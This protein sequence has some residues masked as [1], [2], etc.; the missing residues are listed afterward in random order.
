MSSQLVID[1][2]MNTK[3]AGAVVQSISNAFSEIERA[4][5]STWNGLKSLGKGR[6][7]TDNV[8]VVD[9]YIKKDNRKT[10][11]GSRGRG[12]EDRISAQLSRTNSAAVMPVASSVT[13]VIS[14][15]P[16]SPKDLL[17]LFGDVAKDMEAANKKGNELHKSIALLLSLMKA[18]ND[19][20]EKHFSNLPKFEKK[21][22]AFKQYYKEFEFLLKRE[23][24]MKAGENMSWLKNKWDKRPEASWI[25][26]E[27]KNFLEMEGA[28]P[29]VEAYKKHFS[30]YKP[31]A[32]PL[33]M[34]PKSSGERLND[35]LKRIEAKLDKGI[36]GGTGGGTGPVDNSKATSITIINNNKQVEEAT[37]KVKQYTDAHKR[38]AAQFGVSSEELDKFGIFNV[39]TAAQIGASA[40]DVDE[41]GIGFVSLAGKL[42]TSAQELDLFGQKN[43]TLA[44]QMGV[45]ARELFLFNE[46]HVRTAAQL[47]VSSQELALFKEGHVALA[48][49]LGVTSQEL[50][51]HNE[52]HIRN[53]NQLGVSAQEL[54][55]YKEGHVVLAGQLGVSSKELKLFGKE[56]IITAKNL[57]VSAKELDT[58][59]ENHVKTAGRLGV[60]S[61][62]LRLFGEEHVRSAKKLGVGSV[63]LKTYGDEHIKMANKLGVG[64][65]ELALYDE[66]HIRLAKQL[67]VSSQELDVYGQEHVTL[68]KKIGVSSFELD[69]YGEDHVKL[70]KQLG[71]SSLELEIYGKENI[72]LAKHIGKTASEVMLLTEAEKEEARQKADNIKKNKEYQESLKK[73][74][75]AIGYVQAGLKGTKSLLGTMGVEMDKTTEDI[76]SFAESAGNLGS[77]IISG[78]PTKIISG[79]FDTIGTIFSFF[80][81]KIDWGAKARNLLRGMPG[82]TDEMRDKLAKLAEEIG[83][84][85]KAYRQLLKD[86]V[87]EG[88]TTQLTFDKWANEISKTLDFS[89]INPN[90]RQKAIGEVGAAFAELIKKADEFEQHGSAAMTQII[91]DSRNLVGAW[92]DVKEI[93]DYVMTQLESGIEGLKTYVSDASGL[94]DQIEEKQESMDKLEGKKGNVKQKDQEEYNRLKD[95]IAELQATYDD[96]MSQEQFDRAAAYAVNIM[97]SLMAE[98]K[99][100]VDVIGMMGDQLDL[101]INIKDKAGYDEGILEELLGMREFVNNNK[102]VINGIQGSKQ[103]MESFFNANYMTDDLFKKFQEDA[104]G[105]YDAMKDGAEM[106]EE[107]LQAIAPYL[108]KMVWFAKEHKM[109]LEEGTAE[110]VNQAIQAGI[111]MDVMLPPQEKM[112]YL[113]EELVRLFGGEV[114]YAIEEAAKKAREGMGN[115]AIETDKW[116]KSLDDIEKKL[117]KDIPS[118]VSDMDDTYQHHVSGNTIVKETLK[119]HEALTGVQG[120]ME[121]DLTGSARRMDDQYKYTVDNIRGYFRELIDANEDIPLTFKD[122]QKAV[123]A[124]TNDIELAKQ[125]VADFGEEIDSELQEKID[126]LAETLGNYHA[127]ESQFL[128]DIIKGAEINEYNFDSYADRTREILQDL[129]NGSLSIQETQ[130]AMGSSFSAL[131]KEAQQLGTEGSR[132]MINLLKEVRAVGLEVAEMDD[133]VNK[134]L[135]DGAKAFGT[136]TSS[137]ADTGAIKDELDELAKQYAAI[138]EE[139]MGRMSHED[140]AAK[141]LERDK[142]EEQLNLKKDELKKAQTDIEENWGFMQGAA[143]STFNAL[144]AQ[145]YSLMERVQ[146]MKD[147]LADLARMAKE[148]GLEVSE[149]IRNMVEMAEFME[150]NEALASRIEAT[151]TMMQALGDS[152]FMTAGDF[153]M[154]SQQVQN[155]MAAVEAETGNSELALRMVAPALEDLIKY[156]ESYGYAIDDSTQKLIDQARE[157]GV[158]TEQTKS[159]A[160]IT[161]ELLLLI[162]ETLGATIPESLQKV[163]DQAERSMESVKKETGEWNEELNKVEGKLKDEFPEAILQLDKRYTEAMT[164]N[165][166]VKETRKWQQSLQDVQDIL[167]RQLL[168]NAD[169]LDKKYKHVQGNIYDYL[170]KTSA[171]GFKASLSFNGMVNKLV[172]LQDAHDKLAKKKWRSKRDEALMDDYKRQIGELKDAVEETAPTLENFGK[173][174]DDLQDQ[175]NGPI[176]VN[177]GMIQMA[178]NLREQGKTLEDIDKIIGKS[179]ETGSKGLG[180]WVNALG[181]AVEQ[182]REIKDLRKDYERLLAKDSLSGEETESLAELAGQLEELTGKARMDMVGDTQAILNSQEMM[183]AYFYSL[184]AE[185]KNVFEV[186]ELLGDGFQSLAEKSLEDGFVTPLSGTFSQLYQL[187]RKM[188][189]NSPL[190]RG[191]QGLSGALHGIG[192]SM[193]YMSRESFGTFEQASVQAFQKLRSAGFQQQQAL[194]VMAPILRD[195]GAY[196]SEYGYALSDP[197]TLMLEQAEKAHLIREQQKSDTERLID[198]NMRLADTMDRVAG[199]FTQMQGIDPFGAMQSEAAWLVDENGTPVSLSGSWSNDDIRRFQSIPVRRRNLSDSGTAGNGDIVFEHVTIHGENGEECV[200][201]FMAAIKGNRYG[202]QNLIRKVAN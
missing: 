175:L 43:V 168:E 32:S 112:V 115:A 125:A 102:E 64:S 54:A 109:N 106:S 190:I 165:T 45:N 8:D 140:R 88:V 148:N 151:R 93:Q 63:E 169:E 25:K 130:E 84:V 183:A 76:F 61:L 107:G 17:G 100:M 1:L 27:F 99:S 198:A 120:M 71:V 135:N 111:N 161:N 199:V 29:Q 14:K 133:Y 153:D 155:Q 116:R 164:G 178:R 19:Y 196:A 163:T 108:A 156:S 150:Q 28:S 185:G 149:G 145:G 171:Q 132:S 44:G 5:K 138:E 141:E 91:E 83:D 22:N 41:Y 11:T 66:K 184:Q 49:R 195:L 146:M 52:A 142:L 173:H 20:L 193:I 200:R 24:A 117:T 113:L 127:A 192:D 160:E 57:G 74:D 177:A 3:E 79:V 136:Y 60:S 35:I 97:E 126:E 89:K 67:G 95:E 37:E 92:K 104:I 98:G 119:W 56:D 81:K 188:T 7:V 128:D 46:E 33:R 15:I 87:A 36:A 110:M 123:M 75:D 48:G 80:E 176:G 147:P 143:L 86:F 131:L 124:V 158:L 69:T 202:V 65:H 50:F 34:K 68:A 166:I 16:T 101:L 162:A 30:Q 85:R 179:L 90:E 21:L 58:Y 197:V 94:L 154:F 23:P 12:A 189:E 122:I 51:L 167:G 114:P 26:E 53:A 31:V 78:D 42:G 139:L 59:G 82:V 121:D 6:R 62:N 77:A 118:A 73:L 38:L 191:I 180:D 9:E 55:T 10:K 4:A 47:G 70:A 72:E 40:A 96:I 159:E 201:E 13:S 152:A 144:E 2:S 170:K 172:E 105:Y 157:Q 137:F 187:E 103:M 194:Q 182:I 18:Y 129:L 174:F 186:M 181:P 39:A 134:K